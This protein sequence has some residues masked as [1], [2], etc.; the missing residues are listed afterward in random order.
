MGRSMRDF[1][2]NYDPD[3]LKLLCRA[4]DAAW[5]DIGRNGDAAAAEDRR[6]SLAL[7]ILELGRGGL[8]NEEKLKAAAV[9]VLSRSSLASE[10]L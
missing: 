9:D 1:A 7:I 4:F 5:Q 10:R 2:D 6:T 3:T 8:R